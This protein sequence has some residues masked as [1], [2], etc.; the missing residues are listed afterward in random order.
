MPESAIK[1]AETNEETLIKFI[2]EKC[3]EFNKDEINSEWVVWMLKLVKDANESNALINP[4]WLRA[5]KGVWLVG[6]HPNPPTDPPMF[7]I[8]SPIPHPTN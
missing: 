4:E 5:E 8:D 2:Q 6:I 3:S 7:L 1:Q